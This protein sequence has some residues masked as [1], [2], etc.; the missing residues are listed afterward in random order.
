[1]T[2]DGAVL[3]TIPMSRWHVAA[4]DPSFPLKKA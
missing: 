4:N 1:M 3:V 2:H